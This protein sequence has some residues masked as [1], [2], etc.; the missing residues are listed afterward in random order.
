MQT[1]GCARI[2]NV[3]APK[4]IW[5]G[6]RL[7]GLEKKVDKGFA[8]VDEQFEKVDARFEKV[9]GKIESAVKELR[10]EMNAGFGRIGG[11]LMALHRLLLRASIAGVVAVGALVLGGLTGHI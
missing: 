8:Q 11:D 7:D 2:M 3:A 5:T 4:R 10:E 1:K 9:E 6:D